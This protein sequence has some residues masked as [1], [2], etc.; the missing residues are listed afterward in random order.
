MQSNQLHFIHILK[1]L[2]TN[3]NLLQP[4][5]S[6]HIKHTPFTLITTLRWNHK[7]C[8]SLIHILPFTPIVNLHSQIPYPIKHII[9]MLL[10]RHCP[11]LFSNLITFNRLWDLFI[12]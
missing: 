7:F 3:L 2:I 10:C 11:I 12:T 4:L 8:Y 9:I 6:T 5:Q 1:T